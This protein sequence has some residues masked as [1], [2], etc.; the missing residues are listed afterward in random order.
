MLYVSDPILRSLSAAA[1]QRSGQRVQA[2]V[3]VVT[4]GSDVA[5]TISRGQEINCIKVGGLSPWTN[6]TGR[7]CFVVLI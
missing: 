6:G 5:G 1:G 7:M 4:M 2:S 3:K